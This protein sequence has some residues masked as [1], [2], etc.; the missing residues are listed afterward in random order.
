MTQYV[1][2][3]SVCH[4]CI[5]FTFGVIVSYFQSIRVLCLDQKTSVWKDVS[6]IIESGSV[7]FLHPLIRGF[8]SQ[9][10]VVSI[11]K[12]GLLKKKK[13]R[14]RHRSLCP[15]SASTGAIH[16]LPTLLL[17]IR[18]LALTLSFG[19]SVR[20]VLP[21]AGRFSSLLGPQSQRA[22]V[23]NAPVMQPVNCTSSDS[24][25]NTQTQ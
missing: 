22:E 17:T 11:C 20:P 10:S 23:K 14:V 9:V 13:K 25:L 21:F 8:V 15:A 19:T 3:I 12:E 2:N 24:M 18:S 6:S 16:L 5:Y 7:Y 4:L 1:S